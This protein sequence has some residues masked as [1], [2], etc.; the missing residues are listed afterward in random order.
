MTVPRV[1]GANELGVP[2]GQY[3]HKAKL[4]DDEVDA[5]RYL[6]EFRKWGYRR[7]ALHI[8]CHRNTVRQICLYQRRATT[9]MRWVSVRLKGTHD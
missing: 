3:H 4:T 7:I 1:V 5:I 8:G 9:Y 2:V 6:H